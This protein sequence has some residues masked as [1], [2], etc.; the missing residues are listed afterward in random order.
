MKSL[1]P[2]L[3]QFIKPSMMTHRPRLYPSFSIVEDTIIDE[4]SKGVSDR[5]NTD[6]THEKRLPLH[7]SACGLCWPLSTCK[8][9]FYHFFS[10]V[11]STICLCSAFETSR[12]S[13][14]FKY[15]RP[16]PYT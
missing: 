16:K 5:H 11:S 9:R 10:Q 14:V 6:M 15:R 4:A 2:L 12:F 1:S 7:V 8:Y 13:T 3:R